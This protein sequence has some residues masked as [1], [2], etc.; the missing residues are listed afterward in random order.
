MGE[1]KTR[2]SHGDKAWLHQYQHI[3]T[4][5]THTIDD[6]VLKHEHS[7]CIYGSRAQMKCFT[8]IFVLDYIFSFSFDF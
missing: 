6:D 4:T 3:D 8:A 5:H 7:D 2:L 1:M